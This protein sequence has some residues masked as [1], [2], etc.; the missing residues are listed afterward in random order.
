MS[1]AAS[2]AW[3]HRRERRNSSAPS[4][5]LRSRRC[6]RP[7]AGCWPSPARC[8]SAPPAWSPG[9]RSPWSAWASCCSSRR[10]TG[11]YALA[12]AVSAAYMIANARPGDRCRA[13]CSTGSGRPGCWRPPA[14][15]FAVALVLLVW[16]VRPTGRSRASY[17]VAALAG[18]RAAPGRLL[19]PRPLVAR[20]RGAGQTCRRRTR[21]RPWPTRRSSSL[22]PI[23]G[24]RAGHRLGPGRR[25][26]GR[27]GRRR[28]PARWPCRPAR[29]RAPGAPAPTAP[30]ARARGCRGP[31]VAPL[32]VVSAALGALFG[33]A[34]VTTVAFADEQGHRR[35]AGRLLAL[36]ALGSLLA[37]RRDRRGRLAPRARRVRV[38]W[39]AVAMSCDDG[40]AGAS[41]ARCR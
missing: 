31:R 38:R 11:S 39:G 23:A 34:E 41:S 40:A 29:H 30:P 15:V 37:G 21:S 10:R 13:G 3:P 4:G 1:A 35:W 28:R 25:A 17:A 24:H 5:D 20:A 7:T 16:S 27:G 6:S 33:A 9:C 12:G 18:R 22:G 19:R 2:A 32:A 8:G 36:W 26:R 14:S